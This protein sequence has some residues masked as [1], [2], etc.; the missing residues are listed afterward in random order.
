MKIF[1]DIWSLLMALRLVD[2]V[3]FFAVLI[4]MILVVMLIY[5]IM[6]NKDEDEKSLGETQEM[7]IAKELKKNM[8]NKEEANINFT[9][10]EKEQEDKAIISYDELLK[11]RS[12]YEL[13]YETEEMHDDLSVKKVNLDNLIK[14]KND[15]TPNL[16]VR[17]IS[18]QKEEAFLEAL[19]RL[20]QELG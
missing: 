8:K 9:N 3:F 11:K 14:E 18:F 15:S 10:Y 7:K 13:N 5:F 2:V 16:E 12:N 6:A 19:K 20:Q 1:S 4:L 17:V